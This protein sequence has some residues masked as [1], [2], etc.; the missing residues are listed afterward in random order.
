MVDWFTRAVRGQDCGE[1]ALAVDWSATPLGPPDA[2]PAGLRRAV[3]LCFSTRFAVLVSWGPELTMI[4]NDGYREMLGRDLHPQAMGAAA[5]KLWGQIWD[6]V[7]PLFD[8]VIRTGR[9]TWDVDMPLMMDRSGFVEETRFTFSYS[10]LRDDDGVVQGVMDI[11]TETTDQVV[12]RRRLSTLSRLSFALHGRHGDPEEVAD[13]ATAVLRDAEDVGEVHVSLDDPGGPDGHDEATDH[14]DTAR[15]AGPVWHGRTLFAPLDTHPGRP[16][17]GTI[18]LRGNEHRPLDETQRSFLLL[19]ASTV[20][21]AVAAAEEHRSR[22]SR[23]TGVSD[24]LQRA[25]VPATP[26]SPRWQTRYRPADDSLAVGGDWFDVV[27]LSSGRFGL[28]VGDCVGHGVVAAASM[29]RLSS[30]G[31]ALMLAGSGPAQVL[32][33]LDEFARTV[34]GA[35]HATVFCG[36]VDPATMTLTY[37]SAGHPPG[38]LVGADGA[39]AWLDGARGPLLTLPHVGRSEHTA[40]LASG[41]TVLLYTDGLVER[42]DTRLRDGLERLAAVARAECRGTPLDELPERLLD[43]MLPDGARDDV[44]LV[45][46]RTD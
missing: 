7:G 26:T 6:E 24:A 39:S 33:M 14:P 23:L 41:D 13:L 4:Y 45:A 12:D 18:T 40:T 20:S 27:E 19:L 21:H 25:M 34:P 17:L 29:G 43:A 3:E 11:A 5:P 36:V 1:A 30:A 15:P 16:P 31:R 2:W 46:Y 8:D 22:V 37:S 44:A 32:A 35:E 9:P 38:L 28:V 10:P 42:R